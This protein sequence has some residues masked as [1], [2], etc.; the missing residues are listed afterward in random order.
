MYVHVYY[1]F[2]YAR[3][4]KDGFEAVLRKHAGSLLFGLLKDKGNIVW[5]N[6][7]GCKGILNWAVTDKPN[8]T[9]TTLKII[10]YNI[11][12]MEK[13]LNEIKKLKSD[14]LNR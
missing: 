6:E 7:E 13:A 11:E 8:S 5:E 4:T 2:L 9:G 3:K 1:E 12:E 10:N 14:T